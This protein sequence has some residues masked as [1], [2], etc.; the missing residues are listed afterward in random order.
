MSLRL[1]GVALFLPS[2]LAA[3]APRPADPDALIARGIA[4]MGGEAALRSVRSLR[5]DVLTQWLRPA[6][7]ALP[8]DAM[9]SYERNVELRDYTTASWRN[10]RYISPTAVAPFVVDVVRDTI[11][12]RLMPRARGEA[13]SWGPLNV[14]YVEERRELFGFAPDRLLL[15]LTDGRPVRRLPD[16]TIAAEPHARLAATIEQWPA[17]IFLDLS[18]GL[19]TLARFRADEINDFGLASFGE[20]EVEFWFSNWAPARGGLLL[21]RQHDVRRAG[22]PYKRMTILEAEVDAA[23]PRDSFTVSDSVTR[24]F[25]ATERRPMWQVPLEGAA[26]IMDE[27]FASIPPFLG[28]GGAVLVGGQ[29][30]VLETAQALGA[31]ALIARWLDQQPGRAPIGGAI[32]TNVWTGNGGVPWFTARRL[33]TLVAP[34]AVPLLARVNAGR[35]GL[36]VVDAPG[37]VRFGSDSLWLEPLSAPQ[38]SRTMLV[39]SPTRRW[40]WLPFAG[41]PTNATDE[42]SAIARLE[43]RGMHVEWIGGPRAIAVARPPAR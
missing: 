35:E 43:S 21:A 19:P 22:E 20:H 11:A 2:M 7:R 13:P 1:L 41:I 24:A 16:T 23:A 5:L 12:A 42:E 33:P 17:E 38:F 6:S 26:R 29:W 37:W 4:R 40:L 34:G 9:G 30:V 25:L 36:T 3:Q 14:A 18:D 31:M 15:A 39:Y 28:S 8:F 10:S 27:H 32:V